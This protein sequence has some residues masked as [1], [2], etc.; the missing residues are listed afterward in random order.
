MSVFYKKTRITTYSVVLV[1]AMLFG[2]HVCAAVKIGE[3]ERI[4]NDVI[5]M[6]KMVKQQKV[7]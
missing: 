5:T 4:D 7:E 3:N 1:L 2:N 6:E